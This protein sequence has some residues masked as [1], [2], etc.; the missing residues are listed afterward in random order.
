MGPTEYFKRG[1]LVFLESLSSV[2]S[3][4]EFWDDGNDNLHTQT[5]VRFV[6]C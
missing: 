6:D 2:E 3:C 4:D 1:F 5:P